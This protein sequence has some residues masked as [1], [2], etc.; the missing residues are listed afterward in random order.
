MTPMSRTADPHENDGPHAGSLPEAEPRPYA[1]STRPGGSRRWLTWPVVAWGLWDWGSAAF[2]AVITTFVFTV[3][4]TS[5]A[6][7]DKDVTESSLSLGL[8]IAGACIALLAPVTGQRSD[9]A[10][11]TIFWLG[12]YTAVVVAISAGLFFVLPAPGYLWLGITLLGVGNVFFELAS[13]NYN[14]LLASLAPKDKVGAVSG[15]GWGMGYLGGIVLLLIL[16]VGF[17]NPEVGW[18]GVTSENGLNVRAAMLVAAAWF[19]LSAIPVLLTQ[20]GR[21]VRRYRQDEADDDVRGSERSQAAMESEPA[22][23][24][25]RAVKARRESLWASYKRL[26]RTLVALYRSHPEVLWFLLAAAVFRD[27]LAGVFTY[28]GIIAQ[29]T[30]GFS[31]SDVIIFAIAANVVAGVATIISG[32]LDDL[33]GPRRVI[34]G[35]LGILVV[36]GMLVF[37]LHDG[38][39]A[40]FWALGLTLSA[41]VG[42]AQSAARSFLA[43]VIPTGREGEIF[44]LY[45][46]TGRAVS[47]LAPAMYGL[48]IWIGKSV[49]GGE[50][51]YWGILGIVAVL[52]AGL[53]LMLRVGDPAGHITELD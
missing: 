19:G 15:L 50:A 24:Q 1:G 13:V 6:F 36:A 18:F 37:L 52:G 22:V 42:P 27:G 2:N 38:G 47:F 30:F 41:C 9:R 3:Y 5:S 44:G 45:A 28:G 51:S 43:R 31:S 39:A 12:A 48:F 32:R 7:G 16:F 40:V 29:N 23:L 17:I 14:G 33:L 34:L 46:T 49:V 53:V 20:S 26:W 4:L 8:T 11:R 10:G 25:G 21:G 35:S